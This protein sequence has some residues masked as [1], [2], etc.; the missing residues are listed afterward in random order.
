MRHSRVSVSMCWGIPPLVPPTSSPLFTLF[1]TLSLT[2]LYYVVPRPLPPL[3][4]PST[5]PQSSRIP[6]LGDGLLARVLPPGQLLPPVAPEVVLP[7]VGPPASKRE[8]DRGPARAQRFSATS[9]RVTCG[10]YPPRVLDEG[11]WG[12]AHG[13]GWGGAAHMDSSSLSK[14]LLP[15]LPL[16]T[17]IARASH[18]S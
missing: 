2:G 16:S 12:C 15:L 7:L 13:E 18:R 6:M 3:Y 17:W 11:G 14:W 1:I 4:L 8:S 5:S 10:S 9:R